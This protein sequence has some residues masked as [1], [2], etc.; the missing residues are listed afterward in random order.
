LLRDPLQ[1][2]AAAQIA[3]I[4][5]ADARENWETMTAWRDHL[6]KHRTLEAAYLEMIRRNIRFPHV[7]IGQLTQAILRN[8]L[9]DCEDVFV[10]RAAEMLFRPQKLMLQDGSTIAIDQET[11]ALFGPK[12]RSPLL[13]LL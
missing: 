5:D 7:L 6:A 8:L 1:P 9:D 3:A 12:L 10:L 4:A 2:V 11:E 13:A